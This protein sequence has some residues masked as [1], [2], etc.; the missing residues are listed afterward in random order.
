[1]KTDDLINMLASGPDLRAPQMPVRRFTL[2]LVSGLLV[3]TFMML[4]FLGLRPNLAELA[5]LPAFWI[6]ILFVTTLAGT[7]WIASARLASPGA[8]IVML[9]ALIAAPLLL[10]W[11]AAAISLMNAG[12]DERLQLFWGHTWRYCPFLIATLS[13]PILV[14]ILKVMRDMAP[15]RL[16]LAGATA[17]FAA[18][19]AAATVYS[20]HC[21][22]IEAPFVGFWYLLG[23]LIPTGIGALIGPRVLR[24]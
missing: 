4:A 19:A 17:G 15:T 20:L 6:K 11:I 1:M 2:L 23:I 22:E 8:R 16:R 9:P 3:S 7:G 18:G 10:I 14:A 5:M 21:P 12:P 24:W 13:V